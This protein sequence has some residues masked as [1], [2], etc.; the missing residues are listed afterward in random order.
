MERL[1]LQSKLKNIHQLFNTFNGRFFEL[2]KQKYSSHVLET[3]LVRCASLIEKEILSNGH[4]PEEDAEEEDEN[5][6]EGQGYVSMEN[7]LL[8]IIGEF[9]PHLKQMIDHILLISYGG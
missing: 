9:K 5:E 8:F 7:M 4:I 3:F 1:I 6:D 2:S